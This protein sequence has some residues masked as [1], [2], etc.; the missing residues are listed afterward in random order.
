M[1]TGLRLLLCFEG[2]CLGFVG[3]RLS[4]FLSQGLGVYDNGDVLSLR[5]FGV[6]DALW[7]PTLTM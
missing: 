1:S 6:P 3:F 2:G 7:N 5:R 4:L